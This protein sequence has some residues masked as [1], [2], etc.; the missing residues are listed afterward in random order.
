MRM[1]KEQSFISK[2]A[3]RIALEQKLQNKNKVN[4]ESMEVINQ[5]SF[6]NPQLFR[7]N[8]KD[9]SNQYLSSIDFNNVN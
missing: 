6:D 1:Q 5:Y 9:Q 8:N 2:T 4:Y 7:Y 3:R